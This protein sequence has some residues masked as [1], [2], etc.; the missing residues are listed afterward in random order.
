ML[1]SDSDIPHLCSSSFGP[2]GRVSVL[3]PRT[4]LWGWL[5]NLQS[6]WQYHLF[7]CPC[8]VIQ[9]SVLLKPLPPSAWF[10]IESFFTFCRPLYQ[11]L[12]KKKKSL[13]LGKPVF[14]THPFPSVCVCIVQSV[15]TEDQ[16]MAF[17]SPKASCARCLFFYTV[18]P[19]FTFIIPL[20]FL[21][22]SWPM[23]RNTAFC[24]WCSNGLWLWIRQGFWYKC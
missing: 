6:D 5:L 8:D 7:I 21:F 19:A 13:P 11:S 3:E 1:S 18:L 10:K 22:P 4:H 20:S 17:L 23:V 16:T 12:S 15:F 24:K 2:R 14:S 9:W